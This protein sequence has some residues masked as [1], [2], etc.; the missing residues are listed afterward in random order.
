MIFTV[1]IAALV[2]SYFFRTALAVVAP[3]VAASLHLDPAELGSVSA[4]WFVGMAAAQLPVGIAL[5]RWGPR[6][7]MAAGMLSAVA[8]AALFAV[9]DGFPTAVL[10][11]VLIGI[12]CGPIFM[13]GLYVLARWYPIDR[14][15]I[16]SAVLLTLGGLGN[17][18][19]AT[20]LGLAAG[21]IGWRAVFGLTA[22]ATALAVL[23]VWTCIGDR[24]PGT[25]RPS[26]KPE[27]LR[28]A[29]AGVG[30]VMRLRA[31]WP[32][33]P[34][35]G[36]GAAVI[37]VLR[38]LWGGP[39]LT[40]EHGLD[41]VARGDV[42]GAMAVA[43]LFAAAGFGPI[44]ARIGR[45]RPVGIVATIGMVV[46]LVVLA[47]PGGPSLGMTTVCFCAIGLFGY[48]Y[49]ALMSQG[50]AFI[51]DALVGRGVTVLNLATF[52]AT[53][54]CQAASGWIVAA[55]GYRAL[56]ATLAVAGIAALVAYLFS[57][58]P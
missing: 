29:L 22:V 14:F 18:L 50:R 1:L 11:Q 38:S 39:Y 8:G 42:L 52:L 23:G 57:R 55:G 51:P 7:T 25:A 53:G 12:G 56:F 24:P 5:D 30:A 21:A 43:M 44:A 41:R 19:S 45:Y 3:E 32:L 15:A 46:P 6:R 35:L 2:L 17:V 37:F 26:A 20:P 36:V 48:S 10:A 47:W 4:G 54:L 58:E 13:G 28:D 33:L 27:T 16:L 31:L 9:A 40:D 34:L 49:G